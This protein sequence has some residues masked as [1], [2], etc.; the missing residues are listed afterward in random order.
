MMG[1]IV[2]VTQ[3]LFSLRYENSKLASSV[4]ELHV[5]LLGTDRAAV[6]AEFHYVSGESEEDAEKKNW[7]QVRTGLGTGCQPPPKT[8]NPAPHL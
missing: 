7:C 4:Y 5:R 8:L 3:I 1:H 2:V 6:I